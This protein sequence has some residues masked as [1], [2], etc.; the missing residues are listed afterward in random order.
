MSGLV[1]LGL[2]VLED[3]GIATKIL[4]EATEAGASEFSSAA[5]S[6]SSDIG[7]EAEAPLTEALNEE[8][9]VAE[10]YVG[11]KA[12]ATETAS[13]EE[14]LAEKE[15]GT[16]PVSENLTTVKPSAASA[17]E[18]TATTPASTAALEALQARNPTLAKALTNMSTLKSMS[19]SELKQVQQQVQNL[20]SADLKTMLVGAAK[21]DPAE[22]EQSIAAMESQPADQLK[23][24]TLNKLQ[25]DINSS[26]LWGKAKNF[27]N[28][29]PTMTMIGASTL[30]PL[31]MNAYETHEAEQQVAAAQGQAG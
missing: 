15:A 26:S 16:K 2:D 23:T 30:I 17:G 22:T 31:A 13:V 3:G 5:K 14:G 4:P 21:N 25:S 11:A 6:L 29:N 24:A 10:N 18:T 28:Q 7:T 8:G 9:G 12:G 27:A 20:S 1:S 19:G